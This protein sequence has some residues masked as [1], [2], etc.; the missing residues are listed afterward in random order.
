MKRKTSFAFIL[1]YQSIRLIHLAYY[2]KREYFDSLVIPSL[3]L[4]VL[5]VRKVERGVR[6]G[7][8]QK[9]AIRVASSPGRES[10]F[11]EPSHHTSESI[12]LQILHRN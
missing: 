6:S 2:P 7:T 1:D 4:G 12:L 3:L 9:P 10:V 11:V 5:V 8:K